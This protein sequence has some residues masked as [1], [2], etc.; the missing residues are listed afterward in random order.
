MRF[1]SPKNLARVKL[2]SIFVVFITKRLVCRLLKDEIKSFLHNETSRGGSPYAV[3]ASYLTFENRASHCPNMVVLNH[4]PEF[5]T[6]LHIT[7]PLA[8]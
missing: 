5:F 7:N 2:G 8:F 6:G 4:G 3:V 1:C